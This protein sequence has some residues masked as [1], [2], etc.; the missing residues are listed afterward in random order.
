MKNEK[1]TLLAGGRRLV[2]GIRCSPEFAYDEFMLTKR[3]HNKCNGKFF[4]HYCQ[5]F[6]PNEA[7][8]PEKAHQI[9]IRLAEECFDGYE[10]LVST[11]IEKEHIHNHI[12]VNSVNA[13][14]GRKLHQDNKSLERIR[15]I[16]DSICY[17]TPEGKKCRDYRLHEDKFLKENMENEFDAEKLK[18]MNREKIDLTP[19]LIQLEILTENTERILAQNSRKI[20]VD[21]SSLSQQVGN[22]QE[23]VFMQTERAL[24]RICVRIFQITIM[25]GV[26]IVLITAL[27]KGCLALLNLFQG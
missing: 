22:M 15:N 6:S 7:V 9:G 23:S 11:H 16:S 8:T 26:S 18:E 12:I 21:M 14:S 24:K 19:I 5:S 1:K 27:L 17:T 25:A 13:D 3:M 10:V 4:Y 2:S 20:T